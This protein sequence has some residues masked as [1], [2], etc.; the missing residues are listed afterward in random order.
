MVIQEKEKKKKIKS[1]GAYKSI[2][3]GS[4]SSLICNDH[5]L[6]DLTELFKVF[7]HGLL[8][9]LPSQ[10]ANKHLGVGGVSKLSC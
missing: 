6:E 9:S 7:L 5:G 4:S 3:F 8:L 1:E 10:A 2:A